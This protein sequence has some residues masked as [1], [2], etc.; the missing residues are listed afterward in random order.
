MPVFSNKLGSRYIVGFSLAL[1]IHIFNKLKQLPDSDKAKLRLRL[2]IEANTIASLPLEFLYRTMGGYY[3]AVNPDTVLSRYLN[4]P[5]P[6]ERVRRREGSLHMLVIVADPTDQTRL[7]PDDWEEIIKAALA[8][9]LARRSNDV[10]NCQASHTQGDPQ[11]S[12][13]PKA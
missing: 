8:K 7:P 6:P 12:V 9:P 13:D 2:R 5:L 11:C 1:S 4:L 10:T 3:L